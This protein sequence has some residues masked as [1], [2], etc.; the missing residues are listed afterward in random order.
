VIGDLDHYKSD[1]GILSAL[2]I[3]NRNRF[4][5]L[6]ADTIDDVSECVYTGLAYGNTKTDA[7]NTISIIASCTISE[8][9]ILYVS[10]L[11]YLRANHRNFANI[12]I[13]DYDRE[14][15]IIPDIEEVFGK[16]VT[17]LLHTM[18]TGLRVRF[19]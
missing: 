14:F 12:K 19:P 7:I 1:E 17:E 10:S 4:P 16:E 5:N 3:R 9:T 8:A 18:L 13:R 15:S 2:T 6:S 11:M